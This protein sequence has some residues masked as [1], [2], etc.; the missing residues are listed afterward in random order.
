M[1]MGRSLFD[2]FPQVRSRFDEASSILG[3]DIA[4]LCFEGSTEELTRTTVAQPALL[5]VG[6]ACYDVLSARAVTGE[7]VAG[8]SL[9]E[10]TALVASGALDFGAAVA[11]VNRRAKLMDAAPPGKMSAI[12]GLGREQVE[13]ACKRAAGA[14]V[15]APAN[16]NCPGQVVISGDEMAVERAETAAQEMGAKRVLRLPVSGAFHSPLI[17]GAAKELEQVLLEMEF[18]RPRCPVVANATAQVVEEPEEIRSAL[19]RQM[20]SCVLWE[21][22]VHNMVNKGIDAFVELGPGKVLSGLIRRICREAVVCNV[23]D[24]GS[25]EE[26]LRCLR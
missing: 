11:V 17:A 5:C 25:L 15:V 22:S 9:G 16:Y 3:F 20:V 13:A 14:G 19:S 4:R 12:I 24:C 7:L 26:T 10:Y 18:R 23:E 2:A 8:H 1:G 6:V 21:D